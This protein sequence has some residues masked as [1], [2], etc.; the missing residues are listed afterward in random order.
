M[1]L[2]NIFRDSKRAGK[3][4]SFIND[5]IISEVLVKLADDLILKKD[6]LL[7]EN[8]KDLKLMDPKD[9]KYDRL[10]L[11]DKRLEDI[12]SDLKNVSTLPSPLGKILSQTVRPNGM[13]LTKKSVAFGTIGIIF[14]SRPNVC[15]DVFSLCFK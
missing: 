4:L 14:E 3:N 5:I 11:T 8:K 15:F 2:S 6:Y 1:D 12:A 9:P 10:K 13:L 7:K